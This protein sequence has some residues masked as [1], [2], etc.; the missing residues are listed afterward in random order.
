M[1]ESPISNTLEP[2]GPQ[3]AHHISCV[4][5]QQYS[6]ATFIS[7]RFFQQRKFNRISVNVLIL[8]SFYSSKIE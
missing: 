1:Q 4:I 2:D 6:V 5:A 7:W 8:F 3:Y